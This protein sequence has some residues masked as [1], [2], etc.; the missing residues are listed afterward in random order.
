MKRAVL[1]TLAV[2]V[3]VLALNPVMAAYAKV[4]LPANIKF[5]GYALGS[6]LVLYGFANAW[7]QDPLWL[8]SALGSIELDGYA[9]ATSYEQVPPAWEI[10][11]N[12]YGMAYFTDP[13]GVK[14]IGFLALKWSENHELHQL[15]VVIYSKSTTQ[16]VFQ[17]NTDKFHAGFMGWTSSSGWEK[18]LL[19]Y[20][21][22]YKTGSNVQ[23]LSGPIAVLA[24]R[25]ENPPYTGIEYIALS[26][27]FGAPQYILTAYW[28]SENAPVTPQITIPA[29][30]IVRDVKL[31]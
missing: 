26:L 6:C 15:A 18:P 23:Y 31:L 25:L 5:K 11:G 12:I 22:I 27:W 30:T 20:K 10:Q 24:S 28:W 19:S 9:K 3:F 21:G 17:P 8:G 16:G 2:L 14:A 4:Q 1:V 13:G 29:A 7:P